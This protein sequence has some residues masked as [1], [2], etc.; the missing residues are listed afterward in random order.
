MR[1]LVVGEAEAVNIMVNK[2]FDLI[3][4]FDASRASRRASHRLRRAISRAG[5]RYRQ[6]QTLDFRGFYHGLL[7]GYAVALKVLQGKVSGSRNG[8]DDE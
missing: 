6:A 5:T 7:T 8:G 3:N 2:S 1:H 4:H